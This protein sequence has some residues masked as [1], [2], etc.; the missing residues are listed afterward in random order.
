MGSGIA[1]SSEV[2]A[3]VMTCTREIKPLRGAPKGLKAVLLLAKGRAGL[4]T[5]IHA[6][7]GQ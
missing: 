6:D 2:Y 7:M 5:L 4:K 1:A 3:A